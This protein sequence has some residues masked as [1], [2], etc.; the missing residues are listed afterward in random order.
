MFFIKTYVFYKNVMSKQRCIEYKSREDQL[1]VPVPY[2]TTFG[3]SSSEVKT[4]TNKV[5]EHL[6]EDPV[7]SAFNGRKIVVRCF[8]K[9]RV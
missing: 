2:V 7:F 4:F 9:H 8:E 5:N 1:K 3:P 6:R